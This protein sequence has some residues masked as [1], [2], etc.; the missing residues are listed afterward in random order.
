M[1]SDEEGVHP[2]ANTENPDR[3]ADV[4]FV[5]GLAGASHS[6]WRHGNDDEEGH[7]FWPC[8]LGK[9]LPDCGIWTVG[10]A[11]GITELG[12]PGMIIGKRAGNIATQ[13]AHAGVGQ[14][15]VIFITHSMGGLVVKSLVSQRTMD[16]GRGEL[17]GNVRGI[18]SCGTP[19]R[20][21]DF[22]S[23]AGKLGR[24]LGVGSRAWGGGI[25]GSLVGA[26]IERW[27]GSQAH[28]KE[29]ET[30]AEALDLLHDQFLVWYRENPIAIESYAESIG[31]FRKGW[32]GRPLPLGLV[33]S[34]ASA[35]TGVGNPPHD[36]DAD[37]MSL[38][39]PSP[40]VQP[41]YNLVYKGT[42]NFIRKTVEP[43]PEP[44]ISNDLL[45]QIWRSLDP[46]AHAF[47]IQKANISSKP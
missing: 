20:G 37:H 39:K 12:N 25:F 34:R 45:R 27:F 36:V 33:V 18:V 5:H 23:A 14:R 8:E 4:V 26:L 6:T 22:A 31:L 11:A 30:N 9:E 10:Y 28:V 41:I 24:Y 46:I 43:P 1:K 3:L 35:N 32:A 29:M 13:L 21:S 16:N 17:I 47:L 44:N 42:L 2:I 38:V 19:H 7:F 15:P 40:G